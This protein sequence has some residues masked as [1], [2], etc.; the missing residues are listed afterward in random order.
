MTASGSF[1]GPQVVKYM[2]TGMVSTMFWQ[3][4]NSEGDTV[5]E[6]FVEPKYFF[7]IILRLLSPPEGS[8]FVNRGN[9]A[10]VL[11]VWGRHEPLTYVAH[12]PARRLCRPDAL[13]NDIAGCGSDFLQACT[14][15]DFTTYNV[16]L[17][18]T[19]PIRC[20]RRTGR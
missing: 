19:A 17:N 8:S 4:D 12:S 2:L 6:H 13:V 14:S 5:P 20:Q 11:L 15:G 1:A 3:E 9:R 10:F 7:T 18:D 16:R